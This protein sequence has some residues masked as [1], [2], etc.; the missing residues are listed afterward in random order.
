MHGIL[1]IKFIAFRS[2]TNIY[3]FTAAYF[4]PIKGAPS[5]CQ[6]KT[7]DKDKYAYS[8]HLTKKELYTLC[9]YYF[10]L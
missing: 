8:V 1:N 6:I 4:C 7:F 2:N 10:F 5:A 3:L 9:V